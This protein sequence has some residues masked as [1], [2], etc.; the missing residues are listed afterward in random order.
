MKCL[1][2]FSIFLGLVMSVPLHYRD[3]PLERDAIKD[4]LQ[5][6][7]AKSPPLPPMKRGPALKVP[8][9]LPRAKDSQVG[10][11]VGRENQMTGKSVMIIRTVFTGLLRDTFSLGRKMK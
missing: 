3:S 2:F 4:S 9:A 8:L 7:A 10:D 6:D 5:N 11:A 1:V